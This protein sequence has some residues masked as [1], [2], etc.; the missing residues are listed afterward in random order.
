MYEEREERE[1]CG[2][3]HSKERSYIYRKKRGMGWVW[4]GGLLEEGEKRSF[5]R[6][7]VVWYI[8]ICIYV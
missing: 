2:N 5:R 8:Y 1:H 4:D 7:G 6:L 3:R